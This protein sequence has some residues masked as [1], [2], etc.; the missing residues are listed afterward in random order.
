MNARNGKIARLPR[1]VRE[2]LNE[3]LEPSA[4]SPEVL[5][6]LNGLPEVKSILETHFDGVPVRKMN[7]S[8][9]RQGGHQEWLARQDLCGKA[10]RAA[11][12]S[13]ELAAAMPSKIVG[14]RCSDRRDRPVCLPAFQMER[15]GGQEI[16]GQDPRL[17]RLVQLRGSFA[18]GDASSAPPRLGNGPK[19]PDRTA[20][21]RGSNGG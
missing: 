21:L 8:R 15:R 17:E 16:R 19:H 5:Q 20:K 18:A 10:S 9:W 14:G 3:R 7:L 1:L 12:F 11:E 4:E 6:W 13:K 2:E